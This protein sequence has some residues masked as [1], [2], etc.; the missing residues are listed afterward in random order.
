[1]KYNIDY[2]KNI[3]TIKKIKSDF[4]HSIILISVLNHY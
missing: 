2:I 1:M 3:S 4:P